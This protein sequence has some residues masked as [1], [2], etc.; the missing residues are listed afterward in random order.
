[1]RHDRKRN[2]LWRSL[3]RVF[4]RISEE[5]KNVGYQNKATLPERADQVKVFLNFFCLYIYL[6]SFLYNCGTVSSENHSEHKFT[7]LYWAEDKN[8]N[9]HH[10]CN[11]NPQ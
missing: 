1:M 3:C 2:R 8:S 7:K 9:I 4:D 6:F 5:N 11:E 10:R